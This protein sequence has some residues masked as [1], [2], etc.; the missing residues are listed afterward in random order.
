MLGTL[1]RVAPQL[2]GMKALEQAIMQEWNDNLKSG[3]GAKGL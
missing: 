2:F 1:A 3:V